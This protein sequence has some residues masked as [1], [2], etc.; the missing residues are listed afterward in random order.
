MTHGT[1]GL[2]VVHPRNVTVM[3]TNTMTGTATSDHSAFTESC[4]YLEGGRP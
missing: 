2:V 3:T 1:L 4:N